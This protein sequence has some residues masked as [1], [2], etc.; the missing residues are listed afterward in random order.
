MKFNPCTP[1]MLKQIKRK[2]AARK[3]ELLNLREYVYENG[4]PHHIIDENTDGFLYNILFPRETIAD[5]KIKCG[6]LFYKR[7]GQYYPE[8]AFNN[9]K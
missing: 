4:I 9:T 5:V 8:K 7:A 6:V 2:E 3:E 1:E